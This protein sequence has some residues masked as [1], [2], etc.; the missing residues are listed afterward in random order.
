M[1]SVNVY[2]KHDHF[3][4]FCECWFKGHQNHLK[5]N[6]AIKIL[7]R[8]AVNT[9][10]DEHLMKP[11]IDAV[12]LLTPIAIQS[13]DNCYFWPYFS[14]FPLQSEALTGRR[15][16]SGRVGRELVNSGSRSSL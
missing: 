9:E 14:S 16:R 10:T 11:H 5:E 2:F 6:N 12:F 4:F 8:A 1:Y 7:S 3:D 13:Y 15:V